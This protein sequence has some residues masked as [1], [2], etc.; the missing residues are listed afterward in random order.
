MGCMRIF[1][2]WNTEGNLISGAPP[3]PSPVLTLVFEELFLTLFPHSSLLGSE[4]KLLPF[5]VIGILTEIW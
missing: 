4:N 3:H 5:A 2:P 1:L